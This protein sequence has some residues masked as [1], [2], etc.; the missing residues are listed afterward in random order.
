M[1]FC[2]WWLFLFLYEQCLAKIVLVFFV[3]VHLNLPPATSHFWTFLVSS[4]TPCCQG[5]KSTISINKRRHENPL[6]FLG[7]AHHTPT[8]LRWKAVVC[9][10]GWVAVEGALLYTSHFQRDCGMRF[11]WEFFYT[12][13]YSLREDFVIELYTR[14]LSDLDVLQHHYFSEMTLTIFY[15]QELLRDQKYSCKNSTGFWKI[16]QKSILIWE[17]EILT[18]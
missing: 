17:G 7:P 1:W 8:T 18:N 16:R 5:W 13:S 6:V 14:Y 9:M 12:K 11:E 2:F 15:P 3:F 10:C 4:K